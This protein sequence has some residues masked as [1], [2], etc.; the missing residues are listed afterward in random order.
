MYDREHGQLLSSVTGAHTVAW[1]VNTGPVIAD[2]IA[3]GIMDDIA[4]RAPP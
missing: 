2:T 4:A 3:M 1:L